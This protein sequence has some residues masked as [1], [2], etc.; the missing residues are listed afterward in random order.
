MGVS[1]AG[2]E[3]EGSVPSKQSTHTVL[4]AMQV[5]G[6]VTEYIIGNGN[7]IFIRYN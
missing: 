6:N 7:W 2:A 1:P 3:S 5:Y 4:Q